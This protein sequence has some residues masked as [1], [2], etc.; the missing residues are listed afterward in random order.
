M[1]ISNVAANT[2]YSAFNVTPVK[3]TRS[4]SVSK[5]QENI[6]RST[7]ASK[8]DSVSIST[9]AQTLLANSKAV[10]PP[11]ESKESSAEKSVE[12][13]QNKED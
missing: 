11:E 6:S 5:E 3:D 9:E 2:A 10:T 4:S 1:A 12:K 7:Q 8:T 13:R